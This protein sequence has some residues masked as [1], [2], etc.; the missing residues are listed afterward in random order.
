MA[1]E[2]LI[3]V[4]NADSNPLSLVMDFAHRLLSPS[5]Y[6]CHLCDVTYD[7]F[8]MKSDWKDFIARLPRP[9][10]F[11]LK[12]KFLKR[13]PECRGTPFPAVF[14]ECASSGLRELVTANE[15]N[16]ARTLNEMKKLVSDKVAQL[17]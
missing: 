3:F 5:S 12:D 2:H 9:S 16:A 7:H 1:S 14:V 11:Y 15:L 6:E 17:G 13:Y 4:Y 8:T 10:R